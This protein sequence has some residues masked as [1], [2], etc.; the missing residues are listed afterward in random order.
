MAQK[1]TITNP[2][3]LVEELEGDL[4][5]KV[6]VNGELKELINTKQTNNTIEEIQNIKNDI[7]D[8]DESVGELE[9]CCELQT[10]PLPQINARLQ[11]AIALNGT[12]DTSLA[13]QWVNGVLSYLNLPAAQTVNGGIIDVYSYIQQ[14]TT[15][16]ILPTLN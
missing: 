7:A 4:T 8:L 10:N 1:Y 12:G 11:M 16:L 6:N 5:M 15:W 3:L 2:N 9:N 14:N 13:I